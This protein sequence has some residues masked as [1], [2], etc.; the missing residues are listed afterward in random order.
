LVNDILVRDG[1]IKIINLFLQC[2]TGQNVI[3]GTGKTE[4]K[5]FKEKEKM[6]RDRDESERVEKGDWTKNVE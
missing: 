3:E 6:L 2:R 4:T 5:K 1:K